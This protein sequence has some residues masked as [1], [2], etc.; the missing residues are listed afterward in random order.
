LR[1]RLSESPERSPPLPTPAIAEVFAERKGEKVG[2]RG[3][4]AKRKKNFPRLKKNEKGKGGESRPA[5]EVSQWS[6]EKERKSVIPRP[7][8]NKALYLLSERKSPE[9]RKRREKKHVQWRRFPSPAGPPAR[10]NRNLT[11][12]KSDET[13]SRVVNNPPRGYRRERRKRRKKGG[14]E[15]ATPPANGFFA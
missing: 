4:R 9:G 11:E 5:Q 13:K 12:G 10:R 6:W 3:R 8:Q 2:W 14:G 15:G 1:E 7:R